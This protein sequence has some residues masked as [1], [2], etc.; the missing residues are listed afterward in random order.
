MNRALAR[1]GYGSTWFDGHRA[2]TYSRYDRWTVKSVVYRRLPDRSDCSSRRGRIGYPQQISFGPHR[3]VQPRPSCS[4]NLT[5]G[6]GAA[7][8]AAL[9]YLIL[10]SVLLLWTSG[11][12][13]DVFLLAGHARLV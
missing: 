6:V 9:T 7:G 13:L 5:G 10:W 1:N 4:L 2:R 11:L 8:T 3:R 12:A